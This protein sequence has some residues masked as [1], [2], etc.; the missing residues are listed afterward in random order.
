MVV[1]TYYKRLMCL[2]FAGVA[3][4]CYAVTQV[5]ADQQYQQAQ[6]LQKQRDSLNSQKLTRE[7]TIRVGTAD[8]KKQAVPPDLLASNS[9]SPRCFQINQI[10]LEGSQSKHFNFALKPYIDGKKTLLGSCMD[11]KLINQL[12]ID[13][14]NNMIDKGYVTTRVLLKDQNLAKGKLTLTVL[15]GFIGHIKTKDMPSEGMG[16]RNNQGNPASFSMAMPMQSGDL[17]NLRDIEQTLENFKRVPSAD[18][19]FAISPSDTLVEELGYSD[20]L[21]NWQQNRRLRASISLDDSGQEST[22]KYLGNVTVS[23]DN[24]L[25]LNDIFYLSL[26]HNIHDVLQNKQNNS[27][28]YNLGYTI[29]IRYALLS[30]KHHGYNYKQK[31]AGANEDYIY[32]GESTGTN[33]TVDYLIHRNQHVK[34]QLQTGLHLKSQKNFINDTEVKVQRRRTTGWKTTLSYETQLKQ[35]KLNSNLSYSTG[36]DAFD[37]LVAPETKFGEG[38]A[39]AGII[40]FDI[41]LVQPLTFNHRNLTYSANLNT[42]YAL[43]TLIP[44]NRFSIGSRYTVRGFDG[45]RSLVGDHGVLFKQK[46]SVPFYINQQKATN[47]QMYGGIDAG[48]VKMINKSQNDLLLGHHLVGANIGLAGTFSKQKMNYDLFLGY[49]VSQPKHF[50]DKKLT[51]GF[52]IGWQY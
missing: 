49:P 20:L 47:H 19:D 30:L 22:G 51:G 42:Q 45:T 3:N 44:N 8:Y 10:V 41:S 4:Y 34:A 17:L 12:V 6:Q 16:F 21:I 25:W 50:S 32:S 28:S 9:K 7:T 13:V 38:N 29:P 33:I 2:V 18:A 24:P 46:L 36:L 43:E 48:Y 1:N 39:K 31:V 40:N 37:A 11:V 27:L 23:L 15:P 26:G 5:E 35:T 52:S 14:Q